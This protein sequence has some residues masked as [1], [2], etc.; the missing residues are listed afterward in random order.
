MLFKYLKPFKSALIFIICAKCGSNPSL[1]VLNLFQKSECAYQYYIYHVFRN[2]FS[3]HISF[4]GRITAFGP[5]INWPKWFID[6]Q[7][8][9]VM[10]RRDQFSFWNFDN[11]KMSFF[12]NKT[13]FNPV[14][15]ANWSCEP[16]KKPKLPIFSS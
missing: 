1:V 3:F 12:D 14:W 4:T 16:R 6:G 8:D 13:L 5:M 7:L 11:S 9:L 2:D 10:W 15:K